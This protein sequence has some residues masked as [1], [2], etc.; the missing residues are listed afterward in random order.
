MNDF[1]RALHFNVNNI[2]PDFYMK[3]AL[4]A[5]KISDYNIYF[6]ALI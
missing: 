4:Y 5:N 6:G 2:Q 3:S 1:A